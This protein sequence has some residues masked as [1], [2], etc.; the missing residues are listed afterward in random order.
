VSSGIAIQDT[1]E[2][3]KGGKKRRK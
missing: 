1:E 3:V 2:G